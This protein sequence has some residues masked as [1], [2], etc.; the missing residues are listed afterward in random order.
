MIQICDDKLL[1][2]NL[3]LL[4]SVLACETSEILTFTAHER[5]KVEIRCPYES[6]YEEKKKYLCRGECLRVLKDKVV[7]SESAAKDERFSLN[8]NKSAQIFT[9]TITDLRTEDRGKYWCGIETG[10]GNLDDFT[11][12]HLEIKQVSRV[13][14][15]TGEHLNIICHYESELKNDVKFI[16]KESSTSLCEKSA[17]KV[18]SENNRNGRFSLRDDASAGVFTVNIT[19]LTEEDSGIYWCGAVQRRQQHKNKWISVIDLNISAGFTPIIMMVVI[20][21][22]TG[23]GFSLFIYLRWRQK[24]EGTQPKDVIHGP[25]LPNG[26]TRE[27]TQTDC[28]YEDISS[29]LD[30]PDYSLV[31]PGFTENDASVYALAQLPSSPSDNLNYSSIKFT[32]THLSDRTSDGQETCDYATVRPKDCGH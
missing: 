9:V 21:I 23:L 27:A 11:Q 26:E 12:I 8:D 1:I 17:I 22:L 18:S 3:L 4:M 32:A 7:E 30:H 25:N 15:V 20:G 16:C 31:L 24:K 5:G 6:R 29:T 14:G 10:R 28:D 19:D 13:S 2:F